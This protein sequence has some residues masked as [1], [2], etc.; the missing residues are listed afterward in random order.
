MHKTSKQFRDSILFIKILELVPDLIYNSFPH[1]MNDT[2]LIEFIFQAYLTFF[3]VN[4]FFFFYK[5]ILYIFFLESW[6]SKGLV[7]CC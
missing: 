2:V 7:K 3:E 1:S 4:N 5:L 6:V